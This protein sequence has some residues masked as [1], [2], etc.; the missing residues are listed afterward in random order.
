MTTP[1]R[2]R[3][4]LP[5]SIYE[6]MVA[7]AQAELP[8]ECCGLLAGRLPERGDL[9][10]AVRVEV[11]YPLRNELRSPTEYLSEPRSMFEAM[12]DMRKREIDVIAVYHS[13]PSTPPIPSKK[14]LDR[15]YSE[16]VINFILGLAGPTPELR[17]WWLGATGYEE[18][19]WGVG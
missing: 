3:L 4:L 16:G 19:G 2:F 11:R 14:D 17:G 18:A 1:P 9:E 8:A 12:R 10:A 6:E 13:H 7:H 5:R 15:N